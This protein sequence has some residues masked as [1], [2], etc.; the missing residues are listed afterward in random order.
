MKATS[1]PIEF[2]LY[3]NYPNPFNPSTTIK[4]GIPKE[5]KVILEVFNVLGERVVTLVNKEMTEG[6]H[7]VKFNGA[8]LPG[9]VYIYK[10][11]ADGFSATKKLVLM[12]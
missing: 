5:S 8:S 2:T 3:N 1:L 12:K 11:A 6:Y 4:F 9:G 7:E 10:L